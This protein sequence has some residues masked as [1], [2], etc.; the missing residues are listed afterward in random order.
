LLRIALL[1]LCLTLAWPAAYAAPAARC[2]EKMPSMPDFYQVDKAYGLLPRGGR[3]YCGPTAAA[4]ALVWLDVNG[5]GDLLPAAVPKGRDQLELMR[6]LGMPKFMNTDS[7]KG[8]GPVGVMRGIERYCVERG[9]RAVMAYA[10]W[11]TGVNRVSERPAVDWVCRNISGKAN[12]LLNIGWYT[13]EEGGATRVR[14]GGHWITAVGYETGREKTWLIIHDPAKR[15]QPKPK[16]SVTR[17]PVKCLLKPLAA[18]TTL[19][20]KTGGDTFSGDGLFI[21]HGIT[22]K[23]GADL[24]I[25]DGAVGFTLTVK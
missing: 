8:T 11:R 14:T 15:S 9:Y 12:L 22:L 20:K 21:L 1:L 2:V 10:G 7:V 3:A 6:L 23:K 4:N 17:C 18:G 13:T 25:L 5:F 16:D 24:A 19:R